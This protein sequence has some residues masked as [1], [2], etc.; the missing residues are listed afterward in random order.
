ME[1]I[2]EFS[3][4]S[5]ANFDSAESRPAISCKS[6]G[7]V[8]LVAT[9]SNDMQPIWATYDFND[10]MLALKLFATHNETRNTIRMS[11]RSIT[12]HLAVRPSM[13]RLGFVMFL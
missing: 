2:G 8:S 10:A 6:S 1:R 9:G 13:T 11:N 3:K 7:L 5:G 12:A 4:S